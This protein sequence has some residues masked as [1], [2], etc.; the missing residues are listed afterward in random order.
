M[1]N[2]YKILDEEDGG[3]KG[4]SLYSY[5]NWKSAEIVKGDYKWNLRKGDVT[6]KIEK[7]TNGI[8]LYFEGKEDK[9]MVI[10]PDGVV[11]M[12]E[13]NGFLTIFE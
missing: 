6:S 3:D 8:F 7:T 1:V 5:A 9:P 13:S 10:Y 4:I 2:R 11:R 12:G